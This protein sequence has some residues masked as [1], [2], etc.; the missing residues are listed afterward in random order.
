MSVRSNSRVT[1]GAINGRIRVNAE[2][3]I[4]ARMQHDMAYTGSYTPG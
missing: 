2:A 3:K 4:M 1:A